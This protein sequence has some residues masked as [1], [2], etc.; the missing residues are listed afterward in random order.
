MV[1][2]L[3]PRDPERCI[4]FSLQAQESET[5]ARF[6]GRAPEGIRPIR[7]SANTVYLATVPV[8]VEP[9]VEASIFLT[10]REENDLLINGCRLYRGYELGPIHIVSHA[11]SARGNTQELRSPLA[12]RA[13]VLGV[14]Q[15]DW[16]TSGLGERSVMGRH[17][18]GGRPAIFKEWD[19]EEPLAELLNADFFQIMQ[20]DVPGPED[21]R[22][23]GDWPFGD[24][25]FHLLG[26]VPFGEEDWV[27]FWEN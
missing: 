20:L 3:A 10:E 14:Q 4:P 26:R 11:R 16:Y 8:A 27:C 24:G 7:Q 23:F 17:K 5:G 6:G 25:M 15:D 9:Y 2:L 22:G 13:I 19:L 18:I 21:A 1:K 12:E